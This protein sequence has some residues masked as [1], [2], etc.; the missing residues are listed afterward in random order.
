MSHK[1]AEIKGEL[2]DFIHKN[3]ALTKIWEGMVS[4]YS[5]IGKIHTRKNF[6]EKNSVEIIGIEEVDLLVL[7]SIEKFFI[8]KITPSGFLKITQY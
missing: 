1:V 3:Q 4:K 7:E 2:L 6:A 8:E 5:D